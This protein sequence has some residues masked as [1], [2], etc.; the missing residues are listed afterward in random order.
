MQ[1]SVQYQRKNP[2]VVD[3]YNLNIL[4]KLPVQK[5]KNIELVTLIQFI[6]HIALTDLPAICEQIF[7]NINAPY[8]II[9]TPNKEFNVHF[10]FKEGQMRHPDHLYQWTR[11]QFQD[12]CM[13]IREEYG[14][15]FEIFG[16]G[17]HV[18]DDKYGHCSQGA[19]F[20]RKQTK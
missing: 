4:E 7:K 11:K 18:S 5:F 17:Q 15:Q 13:K 12:F 16:I 1:D 8:A 3:L 10:N 20:T 14:Y 9:T 2:L 19:F 6:Q